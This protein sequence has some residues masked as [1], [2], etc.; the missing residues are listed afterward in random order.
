MT[1]LL[2]GL[3]FANGVALAADG[4]WVAVAETGAARVRRLWLTGQRAGSAEDLVTGLPGHPDNIALGS[5]GLVWTLRQNHPRDVVMT[6]RGPLAD[7]GITFQ[8][9]V[10]A[11]AGTQQAVA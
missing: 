11:T 4:S 5:D 6:R 2:G 1:E 8:R 3:E 7:E 10:A 9:P